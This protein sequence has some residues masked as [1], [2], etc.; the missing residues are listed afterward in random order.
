M[1]CCT[2]KKFKCCGHENKINRQVIE[3]EKYLPIVHVLEAWSPE[4]ITSS[5]TTAGRTQFHL[6]TEINQLEAGWGDGTVGKL[7]ASRAWGLVFSEL[8][9]SV[10]EH[11]PFWVVPSLVWWSLVV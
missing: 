8:M 6:K 11:S 10:G 3:R 1:P 5:Y 7:L 2:L 4:G 9:I